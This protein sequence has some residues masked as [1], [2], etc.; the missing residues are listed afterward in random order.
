M[1]KAGIKPKHKP[2]PKR[3]DK[4]QYERFLAAAR[5]LGVDETGESFERVFQKIVPP[6][7][8]AK[9]KS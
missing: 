7:T 9:A 6:R 8:A 4:A 3:T 5:K 2:K 1:A